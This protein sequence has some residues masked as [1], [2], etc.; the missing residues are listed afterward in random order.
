M[1]YPAA[2]PQGP[3]T[4]RDGP[5]IEADLVEFNA[6]ATCVEVVA[7]VGGTGGTVGTVGVG[8]V[9]T[10]G[11]V[12]PGPSELSRARYE[13]RDGGLNGIDPNALVAKGREVRR[14]PPGIHLWPRFINMVMIMIRGGQIS[15]PR[16]LGLP[17]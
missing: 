16:R 3:V 13:R 1:Q 12:V 14:M 5:P 9:S 2:F 11:A 6:A 17:R 4:P 8:A 7:A 10:L 15:I